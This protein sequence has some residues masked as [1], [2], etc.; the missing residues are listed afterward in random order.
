MSE[1]WLA[2]CRLKFSFSWDIL[3]YSCCLS[4][5][6]SDNAQL[7]SFLMISRKVNEPFFLIFSE[8]KNENKNSERMKADDNTKPIAEQVEPRRCESR[9]WLN[10]GFVS[11]IEIS[12]TFLL[13]LQALLSSTRWRNSVLNQSGWPSPSTQQSLSTRSAWRSCRDVNLLRRRVWRRPPARR[14]FPSS[15]CWRSSRWS[16]PFHHGCDKFWR[17]WARSCPEQRFWDS[18]V[19]GS[20]LNLRAYAQQLSVQCRL[21]LSSL[22][23]NRSA[24]NVK[25][26]WVRALV[27]AFAQSYLHWAQFEPWVKIVS[28][29]CK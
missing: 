15:S 18:N 27:G 4:S 19:F 29:F 16:R 9:E 28:S 14:C 22:A 5:G 6:L 12:M 1:I 7:V 25:S 21:N 8:T 10:D 23:L 26:L 24:L 20:H 13:S 17:N 3:L 2:R 11:L